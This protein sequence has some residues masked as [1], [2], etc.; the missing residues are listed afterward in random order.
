[1]SVATYGDVGVLFESI[2]SS[3]QYDI[4]SD[5]QLAELNTIL[6]KIIEATARE[7][8]IDISEIDI[9]RTDVNIEGL[10]VTNQLSEECNVLYEQMK[11]L[12]VK[13]GFII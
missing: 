4:C 5:E 1:M 6:E 11:G 13:F 8:G 2:L 10:D 7:H 12:A 9:D 3:E